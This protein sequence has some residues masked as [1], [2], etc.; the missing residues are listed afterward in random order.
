MVFNRYVGQKLA[1]KARWFKRATVLSGNLP[2]YKPK[3]RVKGVVLEAFLNGRLQMKHFGC[4]MD[5]F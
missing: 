1:G 5:L 4:C 3:A 2:I